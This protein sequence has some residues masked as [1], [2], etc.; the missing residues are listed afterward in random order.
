MAAVVEENPDTIQLRVIPFS[1]TACGV[2]GAS[3]F[4][5]ID[6][7][8]PHLPTL[9]WLETVSANRILD[10]TTQMRELDFTHSGAL[11]QSVSAEDSLR[12]VNEYARKLE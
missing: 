8:G 6:F 4:H 5:L 10:D 9:A 11:Q 7:S 2:F 1:A 3:T 12:L